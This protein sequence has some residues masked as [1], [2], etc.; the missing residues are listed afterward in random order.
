MVI[1]PASDFTCPYCDANGHCMMSD[2][3]MEVWRECDDFA[4]YA[5]DWEIPEDLNDWKEDE[6]E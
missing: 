2:N 6:D 1:C 3:P 4:A 5:G